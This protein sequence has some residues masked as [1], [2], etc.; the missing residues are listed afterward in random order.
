MKKELTQIAPVRAGIVLAVLYGLLSLLIA[1]FLLL[2]AFV[3]GN[4][5]GHSPMPAL[6]VGFAIAMPFLYA[7][8]GF[9]GGLI[10]AAV[11]NLIAKWTGGFVFE[12]RD[13][14]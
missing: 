3:G 11:Y 1:P 2:A 4:A 13:A 7:A 8:M 12:V 9:I 10:A 6:G 14:R 5:G